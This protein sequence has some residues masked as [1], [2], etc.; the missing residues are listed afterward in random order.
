MIA[1][2]LFRAV[3]DLEEVLPKIKVEIA[4]EKYGFDK[5]DADKLEQLFQE[6]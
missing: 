6:V 1:D 2:Y 3:E 4:V 5:S